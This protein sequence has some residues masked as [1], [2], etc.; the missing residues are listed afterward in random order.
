[1]K[2]MHMYILPYF[3]IFCVKSAIFG[4]FQ[5]AWGTPEINFKI[6]KKKSEE[7]LPPKEHHFT[8]GA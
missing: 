2:V 7:L 3:T 1:M 5:R 4:K 6:L 8:Q